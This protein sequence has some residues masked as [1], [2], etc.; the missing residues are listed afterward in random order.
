MCMLP[1]KL[2]YAVVT[3]TNWSKF[4][5]L[6][7]NVRKINENTAYTL[8]FGIY[9]GKTGRHVRL[10]KP[11]SNILWNSYWIGG[12]EVFPWLFP[13]L[14]HSRLLIFLHIIWEYKSK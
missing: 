1:P 13:K 8:S 2:K 9:N 11:I 14:E 5:Y 6:E 7:R 12:Y 4:Y 3:Y 10:Y